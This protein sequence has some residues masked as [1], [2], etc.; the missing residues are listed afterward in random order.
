MILSKEV[1]VDCEK[2]ID[3]GMY[4]NQSHD[5]QVKYQIRITG[6]IQSKSQQSTK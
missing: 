2:N 3:T 6:S 5:L 1:Y 4:S